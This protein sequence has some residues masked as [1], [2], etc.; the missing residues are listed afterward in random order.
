MHTCLKWAPGVGLSFSLTPY[1]ADT[2]CWFLHCLPYTRYFLRG[3]DGRWKVNKSQGRERQ[4]KYITI[5]LW[6]WSEA[7]ETTIL[8]QCA[9]FGHSI[10]ILKNTHTHTKE[11]GLIKV[12]SKEA[13]E[14]RA[15]YS[16]RSTDIFPV[17]TSPPSL[18]SEGEKQRPEIHLRMYMYHQQVNCCTHNI[19]SIN[20]SSHNSKT[21][22]IILLD[23]N[24][25]K[26]KVAIVQQ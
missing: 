17:V 1:K 6:G 24:V 4:G 26:N 21:Y 14:D 20:S 15:R 7:R 13:K 5:M 8:Q 9:I 18:F 3:G 22:L 25:L 2:L 10:E 19:I 16:L 23:D 12:C 11:S